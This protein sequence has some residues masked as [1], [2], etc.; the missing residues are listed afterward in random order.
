MRD[1]FPEFENRLAAGGP[2]L[3]SVTTG[4]G[5]PLPAESSSASI[6]DEDDICFR[7]H[8]PLP[9]VLPGPLAIHGNYLRKMDDGHVGKIFVL[10]ADS[11]QLGQ[12][13]FGAEFPDFEVR[14]P[15]VTGAP[16]KPTAAAD[17][18]PAPSTG[19]APG[20]VR[21]GLWAMLGGSALAI[22]I[23]AGRGIARQN[24]ERQ[25]RP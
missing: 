14:L 13:D 15:A 24:A 16:P 23:V 12:G 17:T 3:L 22:V 18:A 9:A 1:N 20:G 5:T 19:A 21:W 8:Y 25:T 2:S 10:N 4:A 11:D 7:L 6:T